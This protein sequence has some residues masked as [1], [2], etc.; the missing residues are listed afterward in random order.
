MKGFINIL[1]TLFLSLVYVALFAF[2]GFSGIFIMALSFV[3]GKYTAA[4]IV[5]LLKMLNQ[6]Y[7]N[8]KS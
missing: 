2:I 7:H 6:Y 1:L 5:E 4:L 3:L 8:D